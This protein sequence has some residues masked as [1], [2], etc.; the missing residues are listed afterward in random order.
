MLEMYPLCAFGNS[1]VAA[2]IDTPCM[3]FF[4]SSTSTTTSGLGHRSG[5]GREWP[6][7]N[8][9]VQPHLRSQADLVA[10]A[11]AGFELAMMLRE[12]VKQTSDCDGI[13]LGGHGL[14]TWE[15]HSISAT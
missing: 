5:C 7:E 8:G 3:R 15:T 4:L 1:T 2:S 13:V 6:G 11:A 14:F 10:L 12:A 9:R